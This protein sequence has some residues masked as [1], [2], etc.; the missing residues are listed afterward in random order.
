MVS[1]ID[2]V[3]SIHDSTEVAIQKMIE[4]SQRK[5]ELGKQNS[6]IAYSI[7]F[8]LLLFKQWVWCWYCWSCL[9]FSYFFFL[10]CCCCIDVSS[11]SSSSICRRCSCCVVH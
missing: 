11:S 5:K 1:S 3:Y 4:A 10:R 8:L 2:L 9:F 7:I 6:I